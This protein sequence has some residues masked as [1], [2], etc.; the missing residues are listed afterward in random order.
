[1]PWKP[2]RGASSRPGRGATASDAFAEFLERLAQIDLV[3]LR[4][5]VQQAIQILRS[6]AGAE[7][8]IGQRL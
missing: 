1:M 3:A 7:S 8:P 5:Q 6:S 4:G 2:V